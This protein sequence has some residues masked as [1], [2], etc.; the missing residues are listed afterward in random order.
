MGFDATFRRSFPLVIGFA[1]GTA[2]YL[3]AWGLTRL[4]ASSFGGP[5]R[6]AASRATAQSPPTT[7]DDLQH[8]TTAA[9]ILERNPFD[10]GTGPLDK[11][12]ESDLFR[13]GPADEEPRCDGTRVVLIAAAANT[14][15]WSFAIL[16]GPDGVPR[17]RRE[18]DDVSGRTLIGIGWDR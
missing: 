15:R 4:V 9:A 18:G 14:T 12:L 11:I 7:A 16:V 1:L 6:T 2:A 10:S 5:A 8:A 17:M 13:P 3:Q